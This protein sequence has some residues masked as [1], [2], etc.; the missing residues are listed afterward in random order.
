MSTQAVLLDWGHTLFD[1]PGSVD[2]IVNF[3]ADR[4]IGA[5]V[6]EVR[7][8]WD[9]ARVRS[10]SAAEI[11]KGRDKSPML[12]RQCWSALWHELEMRFPG[13]IEALYDF[14]TSAAGWSPYSDTADVLHE[15]DARGVPVVIVSDVAF[16][17]RPIL[18]HYDLHHLI[19]TYVLSGEH[20]TTK[21]ELQLFRI[22][23][24]AVGV[25][26]EH[27]L[28]VGDN[29]VND[30]AAIDVGIRTLLLPAVTHGAPRGLHVVLDLI[31]AS[32]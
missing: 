5:N 22:A 15:L 32:S 16:D 30:G 29:Y 20:G 23:L 27:A 24:G 2:F 6:N 3:A 11:A 17:L 7:S 12:H 21:P 25:A 8:L 19:N 4:R 10:R 31:D 13:V 9:D 26:P 14:E 18:Q 28:M 1:T